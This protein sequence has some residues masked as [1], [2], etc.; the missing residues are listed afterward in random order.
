M[1]ALTE[2]RFSLTEDSPMP[3]L[4]TSASPGHR[5]ALGGFPSVQQSSGVL[6]QSWNPVRY[7]HKFRERAE[8]KMS[9]SAPPHPN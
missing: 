5:Q 4:S 6:P 8:R 1:C 7:K 3:V 9:K 2:E